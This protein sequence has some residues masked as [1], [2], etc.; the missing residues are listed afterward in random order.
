MNPK[1]TLI[2]LCIPLLA[3]CDPEKSEGGGIFAPESRRIVQIAERCERRRPFAAQE[4]PPD[5]TGE[6]S[7]TPH[8]H[9]TCQND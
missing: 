7:D 8:R 5:S 3:G 1:T 6:N 2:G 9:A 4:H